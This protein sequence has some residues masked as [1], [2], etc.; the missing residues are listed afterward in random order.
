MANNE[1]EFKMAFN[2]CVDHYCSLFRIGFS[3]RGKLILANSS[4]L[5][6][7]DYMLPDW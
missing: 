1:S 6:F 2:W 3:L 7:W 5:K 4:L